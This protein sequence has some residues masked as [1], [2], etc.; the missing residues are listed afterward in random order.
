MN[1]LG[2]ILETT[3]RVHQSLPLPGAISQGNSPVNIAQP[4][5]NASTR[6]TREAEVEQGGLS[7]TN[8]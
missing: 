1:E 3:S 6:E 7:E 4:T 8:R 5:M 2:E